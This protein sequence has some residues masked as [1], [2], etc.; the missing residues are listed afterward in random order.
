MQGTHDSLDGKYVK[1]CDS[2]IIDLLESEDVFTESTFT[3]MI[4]H[5]VGEQIIHYC[6]MQWTVGLLE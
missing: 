3:L 4:I 6:T 5:T 2:K 1:D